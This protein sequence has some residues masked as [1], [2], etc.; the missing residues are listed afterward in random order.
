MGSFYGEKAYF[1]AAWR[2]KK[3]QMGNVTLNILENMEKRTALWYDKG[4]ILVIDSGDV[5][6]GTV[7]RDAGK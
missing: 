7:P 6:G 1:G 4:Q 3:L 2:H 5:F